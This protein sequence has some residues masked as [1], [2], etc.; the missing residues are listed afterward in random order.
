MVQR[1]AAKLY[2][3]WGNPEDRA[4]T[5]RQIG[6]TPE[7]FGQPDLDVNLKTKECLASTHPPLFRAGTVASA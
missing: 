1:R 3:P 6:G 7:F 4:K 2:I 5:K